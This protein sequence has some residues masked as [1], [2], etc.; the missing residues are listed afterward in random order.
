MQIWHKGGKVEWHGVSMSVDSIH[1]IPYHRP[2]SRDSCRVA[3]A[4]A[5]VDSVRIGNKEKTLF[6]I[7]G[8]LTATTAFFVLSISGSR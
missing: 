2:L 4:R 6:V 3:I 8:V 7:A 1:G 5:H